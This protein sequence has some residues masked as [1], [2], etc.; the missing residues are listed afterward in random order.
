MRRL[1]R[2]VNRSRMLR[3][4]IAIVSGAV[5]LTGLGLG[6]APTPRASGLDVPAAGEARP[7]CTTS[8]LVVWVDATEDHAAG[9]SYVNVKLTNLSGRDCVL[10]GYPGVSAVDL[11]GRQLGSAASRAPSAVRLVTLADGAT[12]T[13]QLQ[14]AVAVNF[15]RGTCRP[16][17][18]AGLRIYPP[19]QTAPKVVPI[20]FGACSRAGPV[21]LHVQAVHP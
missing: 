8:E 17:S 20:P 9:S 7:R 12:A 1:R 3:R 4:C 15:P 14:I 18:A 16:T 19:D 10:R 13:A 5:G 6:L 21:Y 11:R 2:A